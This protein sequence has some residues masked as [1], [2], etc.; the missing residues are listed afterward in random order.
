MKSKQG[1]QELLSTMIENLIILSEYSLKIWGVVIMAQATKSPEV[2]KSSEK[3]KSTEVVKSP[4]AAKIGETLIHT[5]SEG[6]D[7]FYAVQ[8][9]FEDL[10]LQALDYQ[11]ESWD[12]WINEISR[13]E[14][15]QRKLV[16]N[17]RE[18]AKTNL[19]AVFGPTVG[20]AVD[21]FYAQF[22][23]LG[24]FVQE[25]TEKSYKES[26]NLM[27]QSQDQFKQTVQTSFEQQ[28][29][30]REEYKNQIK[31]TQQLYVDFYEKNTKLLFSFIK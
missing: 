2:V 20:Q 23:A 27:N 6:L 11:K 1:N 17:Y 16:G 9:D 4:E 19:T 29:K 26:I 7:R 13:I 31:S 25:F 14:E 8:K 22:D 5:W 10:Y 18:S 30:I 3:A 24:N 15:E 28:Q 21:Q 12:K